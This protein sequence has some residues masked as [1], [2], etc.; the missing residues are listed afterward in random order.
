MEKKSVLEAKGRVWRVI[1]DSSARKLC[2]TILMT[3]EQALDKIGE[4]LVGNIDFGGSDSIDF[5][6][7]VEKIL[8]EVDPGFYDKGIEAI[9]EKAEPYISQLETAPAHVRFYVLEHFS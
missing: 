8:R 2:P 1:P 3:P 6:G 9:K 5:S 4:L 7:E